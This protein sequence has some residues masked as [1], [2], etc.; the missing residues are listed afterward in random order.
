MKKILCFILITVIL[1]A[2]LIGCDESALLKEKTTD[3]VIVDKA[4]YKIE[5]KNGRCYIDLKGKRYGGGCIIYSDYVYYPTVEYMRSEFLNGTVS[6]DKFGNFYTFT[7]DSF[8]GNRIPDP[9]NLYVP[10][11]PEHLSYTDITLDGSGYAYTLYY[12]EKDIGDLKILYPETFA[13]LADAH[14]NYGERL[15]ELEWAETE[16]ERGATVYYYKSDRLYRKTVRYELQR[17]SK[18]CYIAETYV[19]SEIAESEPV[20]QVTTILAN[21]GGVY[22]RVTVN[23]HNG[24]RL[25]VDEILSYSAERYKVYQ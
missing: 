16:E 22:F 24:S 5:R 15:S 1:D 10:D 12:G 3:G 20:P 21:D 23:E 4:E 17:G 14:I 9:Y 7:D 2:A 25:S 13:T 11:L 6:H 18:Q 19:L 8:G